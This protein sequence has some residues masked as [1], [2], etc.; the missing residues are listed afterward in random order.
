MNEAIVAQIRKIL[1][2]TEGAGCTPAEAEAAFGQLA[3]LCDQSL[4]Q[5]RLRR[6]CGCKS[7]PG[8]FGGGADG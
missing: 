8:D 3:D 1:A 4:V 6:W 7:A 5:L 2:R